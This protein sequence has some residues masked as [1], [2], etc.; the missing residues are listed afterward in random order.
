MYKPY[1]ALN[2]LFLIYHEIKLTNNKP[3]RRCPW[4]N[5]YRR[6]KWT[7]RLEFKSWTRMIAF[8]IALIPLGK[9]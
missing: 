4:C 1:L 3:L 8:H 2:S 6:G 5:G 9:V 7:R